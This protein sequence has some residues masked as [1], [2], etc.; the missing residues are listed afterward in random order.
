VFVTAED[1]AA[2]ETGETEAT[3]DYKWYRVKDGV[4]TAIDDAI[5]ASYTLTE[6]DLGYQIKVVVSLNENSE[7]DG[8]I[9]FTT[10]ASDLVKAKGVKITG[11]VHSYN[12][13]NE[14][15][16]TLFDADGQPVSGHENQVLVA[17]NTQCTCHDTLTTSGE[18]DQTFTIEGVPAGT[19]TLVIYKAAH[20]KITISNLVVGDDPIDFT[21]D[22]VED[23]V[24][25]ITLQCGDINESNGIVGD[26]TINQLD[27]AVVLNFYN[28]ESTEKPIADFN[29]DGVINQLDQAIILNNYNSSASD[30]DIDL[31]EKTPTPKTDA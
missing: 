14:I 9:T 31:S 13:T 28:S 26:D 21:T 22:Y 23:D 7:Y 12:L 18:H 17:A 15:T 11:V 5:G 4:E 8:E 25:K 24:K 27:Q 29:G 1:A 30:F 20:L 16:Y 10:D 3:V 19:Y 6:A 2:D